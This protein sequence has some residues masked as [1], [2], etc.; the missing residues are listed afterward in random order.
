MRVI[1]LTGGVGSGKSTVA[2]IMKEEWGAVLLIADEIG[3]LAFVPQSESYCRIVEY[4]GEDILD[5][6]R[7]IDH[8]R[9]AAAIFDDD[10]KRKA[11]NAIV[12]PFVIAY[13][14]RQLALY[15]ETDAIVVLESAIL[16]ESGC[17]P[18]CD[19]IWYVHVPKDIR[20]ER[21]RRDRHY[22]D[23]KID[24]IMEKQLPEESFYR[25]AGAVI[26]NSKEPGAVREQIKQYIRHTPA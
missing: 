12:H 15:R 4:F 8:G 2:R 20:R 24:S 17:V 13:I 23:E 10:E 26:D 1:G 18:L 16:I 7:E 14:R 5:G 21:L 11:L 3:H 19:E 6:N 22:S 25:V 9:L